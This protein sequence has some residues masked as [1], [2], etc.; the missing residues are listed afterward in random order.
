MNIQDSTLSSTS[1]CRREGYALGTLARQRG[2]VKGQ[3]VGAE[4]V[5]LQGLGQDRHPS[6]T[7]AHPGTRTGYGTRY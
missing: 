1:L 7:V 6:V 5:K 2:A 4:P 3:F